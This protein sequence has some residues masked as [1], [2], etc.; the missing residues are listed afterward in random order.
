MSKKFYK[1]KHF[2]NYREIINYSAGHFKDRAAFKIK[3]PDD[4]Y[5]HISYRELENRYYTLCG[6]FLDMGLRHKRIAVVGGNC[7][8]WVLAYMKSQI[9][10]VYCIPTA[11]ADGTSFSASMRHMVFPV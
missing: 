3:R 7:F 2:S 1:E 8:E 11:M 9:I 10:A 5:L 6:I 4:S